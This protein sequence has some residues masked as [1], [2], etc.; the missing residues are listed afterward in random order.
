M[1]IDVKTAGGT[2]PVESD[3]VALG[4]GLNEV[5]LSMFGPRAAKAV[6]QKAELKLARLLVARM[7]S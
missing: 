4:R 1:I 2:V 3:F 6:L 5:S 7:G